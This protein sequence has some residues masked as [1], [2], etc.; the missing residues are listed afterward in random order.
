MIS[1]DNQETNYVIKRG[2]ETIDADGEQIRQFV[3][4]FLDRAVSLSLLI[5][6]GASTPAIPLMGA[7]FKSVKEKIK[8]RDASMSETLDQYIESIC[9]RYN[10]GAAEEFA[11]IELLMSWLHS[12]IEGSTDENE[13]D[14][15]I[16]QMLKTGFVSSVSECDYESE[17]TLSVLGNYQR[18][19]QGFGETRETLSGRERAAIDIVNLFT[20]NYDLFN[21]LALEQSRYSYTDGFTNGLVNR[22]SVSEFHR[23]PIDLDDRFRDRLLPIGPFFR[24]YKLHGSVNWSLENASQDEVTRID[25]RN[26]KD[27]S[28]EDHNVMIAPMSSKHALTQNE[29]YSD[30]FREF[31]NVIAQPNSVLFTTGFSF[32]DDHITSLIQEALSRPDFTLISFISNPENRSK[33]NGLG[34]FF[35]STQS[36]NAYFIFPQNGGPFYFKDF[37]NIVSREIVAQNNEVIDLGT[38]DDAI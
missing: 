23:R 38:D 5:G 37:A 29:P 25:Y 17:E 10:L 28:A 21:E 26:V 8:Q 20:T 35:S 2:P 1:V 32:G 33:E 6:S 31:V 24:L 7:T 16:F 4:S 9:A 18:V 36:P 22:F 3:S 19:I 30:L 12:R 14:N 27:H 11:D 34:K 15:S 13:V